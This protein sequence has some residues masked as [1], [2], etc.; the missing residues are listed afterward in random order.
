MLR[1]TVAPLA[2]IL[3]VTAAVPEIAAGA[4]NDGGACDGPIPTPERGSD[5]MPIRG[6]NSV[7][8]DT[9]PFGYITRTRQ[10]PASDGRISKVG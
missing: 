8:F 4:Q 5:W 3:V 1:A 10:P 6:P 9:A 7:P 2:A